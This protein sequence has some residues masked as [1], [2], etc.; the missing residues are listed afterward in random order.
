MDSRVVL[1]AVDNGEGGGGRLITA[2]GEGVLAGWNAVEQG[3]LTST[4]CV[5]LLVLRFL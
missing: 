5:P 2:M 4:S 1:L 3:R